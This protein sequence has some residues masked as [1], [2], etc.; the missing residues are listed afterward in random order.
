MPKTIIFLLTLL[1][2]SIEAE[3]YS[4][5]N[6]NEEVD[7]IQ[8]RYDSIWDPS[9]NTIVFTGS[10]SIRLWT[11]LQESFPDYQIVNSGFGG[12]ETTDLQEFLNPLVLNYSP[13]KVFIYE[14]DNDLNNGK[15]S[16]EILKVTQEIISDI[17]EK[18]PNT[19]IILISAKP[20]IARWKLKG[21]YKRF[22][23]R[24]AK[25]S[26]NNSLTY[27]ADVWTPMMDKNKVNK[28]LFIEDDLHMNSKGYQLWYEVI[29]N[30]IN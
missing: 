28:D 11:N 4:Q 24:L 27:F 14:G 26:K 23:K 3:V 15:T 19:E 21:K 2:C 30:Y 13:Y 12:S 5:N 9:K 8:K 29:K 1:L 16:K 18:Y 7:Q 25:L 20:S 6:F 22:N 17:L 10:S